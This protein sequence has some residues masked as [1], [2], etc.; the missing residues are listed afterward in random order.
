MVARHLEARG[1][2]DPAVLAAMR[3]VPREAFV[4]AALIP[5]AYRDGPLPIGS[6]QTISQ[7]Y[8]VALM[9]EAA[10]LK[11]SDRVLEV[12]AG[13]GYVIALLAHIV[14]QVYGLERH[15]G[16][17]RAAAKRL[18][19]LGYQDVVV[20]HG[21]GSEGWP[22]HSP[23]DA[24]IVSAGSRDVPQPLLDQLVDGGRLVIPVG[25]RGSQT[26]L[27]IRRAADGSI[28]QDDLGLV[29]FVPLVQGEGPAD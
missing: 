13:S 6:G 17:A 21:D 20:R 8:V 14:A 18:R 10:E 28:S 27:R 9:L 5:A 24:I 4:R 1:I 2:T 22:E 15:E 16:L 26:L 23:F 19:G 11:P 25:S 29:A 7:P 12:G 3:E